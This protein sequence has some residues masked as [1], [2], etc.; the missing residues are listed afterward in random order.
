MTTGFSRRMSS[1]RSR[2]SVTKAVPQPSLTMW[3]FGP[4]VS[5]TSSQARGPRHLSST[6][7]RPPSRL[8]PRSKPGIELFQL[9]LRGGLHV[10]VERVAVCVD[11][12]GQWA[13]VLDP[14]L[15]EALG[16][17]LLPGNLLDL[18]DLRGLERRRAADDCE[19]DHAEPAHRLDSLVRETAFA[20]DRA[21][22]VLRAQRLG[23]ADHPRRGRR[24]DADGVVAAVLALAD[25]RRRVEQERAP[26]VHRRLD[27]LVDDPD[28]RPVAE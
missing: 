8:R 9:L 20:A 5:S 17:Q 15:P 7:V 1:L 23:E 6:C 11:A 28:L 3:M 4:L 19:I 27:A 14:K 21:D 24:A 10:V 13:E 2:P 25:A 18:L 22:A 16:H 12:D 26:K